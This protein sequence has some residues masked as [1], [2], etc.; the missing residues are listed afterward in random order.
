MKNSYCVG[1][2]GAA[3]AEAQANQLAANMEAK[4]AEEEERRHESKLVG[5]K[6]KSDVWGEAPEDMQL[7][8][9]KM[10]EALARAER[11]EREGGEADDRK[12]GCVRAGSGRVWRALALLPA[13][14][15]AGVRER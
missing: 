7:D 3:A 10:R 13:L 9:E 1:Q 2:A 5:Y 8:K 11:R 15:C 6:P 4:A 14:E 12:R